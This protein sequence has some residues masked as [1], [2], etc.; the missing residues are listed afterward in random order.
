MKKLAL[1]FVF[2][3][4]ATNLMAQQSKPYIEVTGIARF[5]KPVKKY[6]IGIVV[7]LGLVYES[8]DSTT[9]LKMLKD[10]YFEKLTKANFDTEKLKENKFGYLG[11]GFKKEGALYMFET[12]SKEECMKIMSVNLDGTQIYS[13]YSIYELSQDRATQ[14][15]KEA[16]EK[17]KAKAVLVANSRGKKIGDI[18]AITDTNS[19]KE[20]ET[21]YYDYT[22][23]KGHYRVVVRYELLN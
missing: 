12:T 3:A 10:E 21:I 14:L 15:A 2:V 13:K 17:A 7:S 23:E 6:A 11:I 5:D 22:D 20:R 1:V 4:L 8:S 16:I 9:T 19:S 18:L